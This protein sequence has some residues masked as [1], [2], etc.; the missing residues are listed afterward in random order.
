MSRSI[1]AAAGLTYRTKGITDRVAGISISAIKEMP[2]LATQVPGAISLGQGI[3][4]F[5]TPAHIRTAVAQALEDDD[6]IG[7]YSLQPGWP[8]LREA[9]ARELGRIKGIEVDPHREVF[10][11]TG[12][13]EAL[14]AAMMTVVDPGGEVIMP[15]PNYASHV[16]Q[17]CLAGGRVVWAPLIEQSGWRLDLEAISR[18]I[19]N[20]TRAIIL[21]SPLNPTGTVFS[22]D[23]I[24][25]VADL[26]IKNDLFLI[27]DEA[28]DF[29]IYDQPAPFS[30]T[31]IPE[32]KEQLIA[33]FS[34]SK[35]YAMT[36][37]RVGY[38]YASAGV[39]DQVLKV[40]DALTISAPTISQVAALAAING[41]QDC[42][43]EMVSELKKRRDLMCRRLDEL[44]PVFTYQRP[45]GAYYIFVRFN[46]PGLTSVDLALKLLFAAKG[47]TIPGQVFGP[48]GEKFIRLS[49]GG[50]ESQIDQAFDRIAAWLKGQG[51]V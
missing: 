7:K 40:H 50:E 49:F 22:E 48:T 41:P 14:F 51:L 8:V 38:M 4:S 28:Y 2:I 10:I 15:S 35:K 13:M 36:G 27:S 43:V 26:C 46:L 29:M 30:A 47:I 24:R 23:D 6:A 25:G 17:V 18:A 31:Q 37:W 3:P 19:T 9:V 39:I 33:C 1:L 16:E 45:G 32:L 34:F 5:R 42:V 44:A 11:S 21:C 12:S 20:K